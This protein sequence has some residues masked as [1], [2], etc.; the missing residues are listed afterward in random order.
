ME[1]GR[2]Y[3]RVNI[4]A[5]AGKYAA[6]KAAATGQVVR[7]HELWLTVST[8]DGA[9]ITSGTTSS[10]GA[11]SGRLY[12]SA[13]PIHW[14]FVPQIAGRAASTSGGKLGIVSTGTGELGGY[15]VISQTTA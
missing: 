8:T 10:T 13:D 14:P 4:T 9:R 5:A 1:L 2:E 3:E 7:I 12:H 15:A 11:V 6:L